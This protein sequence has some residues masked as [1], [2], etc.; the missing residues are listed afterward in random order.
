MALFGVQRTRTFK[1]N[2]TRP[3]LSEMP[4]C[5]SLKFRSDFDAVKVADTNKLVVLCG[6]Q[7]RWRNIYEFRLRVVP[8][9]RYWG[10]SR[11]AIH[12]GACDCSLGGAPGLDQSFRLSPGFHGFS[13]GSRNLYSWRTGRIRC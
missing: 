2:L 9:L 6:R 7:S 1:K 4:G 13:L 10:S 8:G 3:A 5:K 11:V 12:D